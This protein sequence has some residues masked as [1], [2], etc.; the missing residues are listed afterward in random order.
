MCGGRGPGNAKYLHAAEHP[1]YAAAGVYTR[2]GRTLA[3]RETMRRT[4]RCFGVSVPMWLVATLAITVVVF[5]AVAYQVL[6]SASGTSASEV[7]L[8]FS[9]GTWSCPLSGDGSV[10]S[11]ANSGDGRGVALVFAGVYTGTQINCERGI[12]NNDTVTACLASTTPASLFS[13]QANLVTF[14]PAAGLQPAATTNLGYRLSFV[15]VVANSTY[16]S[17]PIASSFSPESQLGTPA[18]NVLA[19]GLCNS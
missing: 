15:N 19:D 8:S 5:A 12:Q 11:S 17:E 6:S 16:A 10:T 18:A 13:G 7:D 14:W 3:E 1:N 4:V 9:D 2:G